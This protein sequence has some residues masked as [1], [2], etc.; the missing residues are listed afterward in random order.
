M[1]GGDILYDFSVLKT[2]FF[3]VLTCG[4]SWGMLCVICHVR[5]VHLYL[6]TNLSESTS[7]D[8][9]IHTHYTNQVYRQQRTAEA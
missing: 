8:L 4:L 2:F 3:Y 9:D 1:L 6:F 7:L 5:Q